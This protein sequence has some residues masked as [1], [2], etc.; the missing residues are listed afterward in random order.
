MLKVL[1]KISLIL[2]LLASVSPVRANGFSYVYVQG[3]KQTPF[4]VKLEDQMLP[5]YG[6]N[7]NLIPQLA[8]GTINIQ[9]LFQ[10]NIYPPQKFTIVVPENGFRGF[11]LMNRNGAF[12][13][14][15]IHQQ[16]Y[17][18][19]G[20]KAVDDHAPAG[21]TADAYVSTGAGSVE[22]ALQEDKPARHS[23]SPKFL[24]N[25]ELAGERTIQKSNPVTEREESNEQG[26]IEPVEE[27][28]EQ[29]E[30]TTNYT[31]PAVVIPNSDCPSAISEHDFQDLYD[32]VRN[33]GEKVKLKYLLTQMEQ[34]YT[35][36]QARILT[37]SLTNDPEK[38]TFLKRV[39]PR[40]T[41]QHNFPAL[42]SLLSTQEWKSYFRLILP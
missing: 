11:L 13:L 25:V 2:V 32:K 40:V 4:Y 6:K 1:L 34:C 24:P 12:S 37:E 38:Y 14:Y 17:L 42:E 3:D 5:R 7:Y 10:Q 19:P 39:F 28:I 31:S 36:N 29:V 33:K 9:I 16:F 20:N 26:Y 18:Q 35:T 30:P 21:N 22:G 15:D 27:T 23:V 41:D 8:P